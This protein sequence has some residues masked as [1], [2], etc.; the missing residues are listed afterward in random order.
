MI[1]GRWAVMRPLAVV[2]LVLCLG[3]SVTH[4][5]GGDVAGRDRAAALT[6]EALEHYDAG[7]PE[8]AVPLLLEARELYAEPTLLYNLARA[9]EALGRYEDA[10]AAYEAYVDE[11]PEAS[12]RAAMQSHID[13]LRDQLAERDRLAREREE[14]RRR[15]EA[16]EARAASREASGPG[17]IPWLLVTLGGATLGSGLVLGLLARSERDAADA[18]PIHESAIATMDR[19]ETFATVANVLFAVGGVLGGAGATW[20]TVFALRSDDG[21]GA[22]VEV[23]LS[24]TGARL[25]GRF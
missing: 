24:P 20:L 21:E 1:V 3:T 13:S 7:A 15:R 16:A 8:L 17:P 25:S 5:Q 14:E 10:L 12:H 18:D 23:T 6:R 22:S 19:A 9:Y 4:A 11:A 2:A